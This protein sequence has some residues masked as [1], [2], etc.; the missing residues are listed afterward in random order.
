M[1]TFLTRGLELP[2]AERDHFVDDGS[3]VHEDSINRVA[4]AGIAVGNGAGLYR[5]QELV[6]R[7]QMATFLT[8]A[9]AVRNGVP[10]ITVRLDDDYAPPS[11]IDVDL[12]PPVYQGSTAYANAVGLTPKE[13]GVRLDLPNPSEV[14]S[15]EEGELYVYDQARCAV[16]DNAG[17]TGI[18]CNDAGL[19]VS[20]RPFERA[21]WILGADVRTAPPGDYRVVFTIPA[22]RSGTTDAVRLPV[23][24]TVE[25]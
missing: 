15:R 7:G 3:S 22:D 2:P 23:V 19:S 13:D 9:L 5:P 20:P 25:G 11:W 4:E 12:A 17:Q 21:E 24:Y 6:T 1:A 10:R 18:G 8:R 16:V 14:I